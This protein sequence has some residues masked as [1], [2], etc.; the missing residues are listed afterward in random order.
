MSII[1]WL[2]ERGA[3]VHK[4]GEEYS[5]DCPKCGDTK[6]HMYINPDKRV[7]HCFRCGY[8][9]KLE[10]VL[11]EGFKLSWNEVSELLSS[12]REFKQPKK[13]NYTAKVVFPSDSIELQDANDG[14]LFLVNKWCEDNRIVFE[15]IVRMKFRWWNGRLLIPCWKDKERSELWYWMGRAVMRIEPRYMNCSSPKSGIVWGLDYYDIGNGYLYVTEGW[16]DAYRMKGIGLLG[17]ELSDNHVD[18]IQKLLVGDIKVMVVLDADAWR[19]GIRV[20]SK[21]ADRIGADR[22]DVGLLS[23]LKDP[24]E[25]NDLSDVLNH[26]KIVSMQ[27]GVINALETL[28]GLEIERKRKINHRVSEF[29]S[30]I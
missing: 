8:A 28:N 14:V 2:L 22:V 11:V 17:K 24:G 5:I 3:K 1:E 6:K 10:E 29:C 4:G 13:Q 21:L 19:E 9:G 16:K 18:T 23:G 12:D 30:I 26:L 25:G 27:D 7:A 20:G 15:D